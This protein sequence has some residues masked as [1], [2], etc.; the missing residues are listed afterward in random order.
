M[1]ALRL[2][3]LALIYLRIGNLTFGGGDPT[4]AALHRELVVRKG[5]LGPERFA[6]AYSLARATPGTNLLAFCAGAAWYLLGWPGAIAAV[7]SATIPS[8]VLAVWLTRAF[9]I[10]S[11]N[12]LALGA[13]NGMLSAAVGMMIAAAW[14]LA[15]PRFIAGTRLR[16]LVL[17]AAP[18]MLL[19]FFHFPPI[20]V[21]GVAVIVG[22]LWK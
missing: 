12:P 8:A 10:G 9:E 13:I 16:T 11:A 20:A 2:A 22:M 3:R 6:V 17:V 19:L 21:L 15:R 4:I 5:W 14:L 1:E 18:A 7:C